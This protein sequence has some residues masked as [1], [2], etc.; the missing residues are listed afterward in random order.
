MG[1]QFVPI[2]TS[3]INPQND[4]QHPTQEKHENPRLYQGW[5]GDVPEA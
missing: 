5:A 3:R 1:N 4:A 2:I